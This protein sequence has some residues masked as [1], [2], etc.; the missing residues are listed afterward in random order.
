MNDTEIRSLEAGWT[1]LTD[2]VEQAVRVADAGDYAQ[3]IKPYL[4]YGD[5]RN[6]IIAMP[7]YLGGDFDVAG[8]KW[9]ASFPANL[10]RGIPR[11]HGVIVLNRADT[12][13]PYAMLNGGMANQL[14]TAAVSGVVLRKFRAARPEERFRVSIIG[15]GPVGRSH[16][17]MCIGL[18]GNKIEHF[19]IYD[20]R[21]VDLSSVPDGWRERTT[22]ASRW[23]EAY[24]GCRVCITCTVSAS[25]YID[26][27]PPAG[28]LL[29]HVSLR[30]YRASALQ[31][32]KAIVVDDWDEVCREN[33][34]IELL[35]RE[36]G[37]TRQQTLSLADLVCRQALDGIPPAETVLFSPMGMAVFDLAVASL[38]VK[39]ARLQGVGTEL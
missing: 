2:C 4:R 11:A 7:A 8:I 14:R 6:R 5:P 15:W 29:L 23:E 13:Q 38:L 32:L 26:R 25:R 22:A 16:M 35:H 31:E 27:I 9:I 12:G 18:F 10:E 39:Q 28:N 17:D 19:T 20:I 21:G 24:E 37:L 33:T 30:D 1:A 34:D 36:T 3:P